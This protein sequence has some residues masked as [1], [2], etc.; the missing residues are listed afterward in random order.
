[1]KESSVDVTAS[2]QDGDVNEDEM[3]CT[4]GSCISD[5]G[6]KLFDWIGGSSVEL[7]DSSIWLT[8][9]LRFWDGVEWINEEEDTRPIYLKKSFVTI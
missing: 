8:R 9:S 5:A 1:M 2:T 7:D 6:V 3:S 4:D